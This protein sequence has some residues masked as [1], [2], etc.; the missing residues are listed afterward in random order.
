MKNIDNIIEKYYNGE[1]S[2]EEEKMLKE[3]FSMD[4]LDNKNNPIEKTLIDFYNSEKQII[5][6]SDFE[7]KLF[8]KINYNKIK[9]INPKKKY[10]IQI[11]SIAA[12]LVIV[13]AYYMIT[14]YN[15]IPGKNNKVTLTAND[16]ITIEYTL[17]ALT[18]MSDY[19]NLANEQVSKLSI[20][21]DSFEKA[22][23]ATKFEDYNNFINNILGI[24]T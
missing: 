16:K 23:E 18:L 3:F 19:I 4:S 7:D 14:Y 11:T 22:Q 20:I 5:L 10:F 12:I 2:E 6:N 21:N 15:D 8:N 17:D 13:L 24:Q 9:S 1:T